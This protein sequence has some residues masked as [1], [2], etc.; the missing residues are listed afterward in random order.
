MSVTEAVLRIRERI[1]A[2]CRRSGRRVEE[3]ALMGVSKFRPAED[4]RAAYGAGIRLFGESRVQEAAGKFPELLRAH[5]DLD[6]H[7]IGSLQR[8]KAK[9]AVSLFSCVQS[10]DR[11]DLIDELALRAAGRPEPLDILFE[12]RTAEATKSGYL[13]L[14]ALCDATEAALARPSLR[15]RGLMTMA[16]YTRDQGPIRASFRALRSARDALSRRF[17]DADWSVLSMGMSNDF[18][19]AVEEGSSLL[20]IGTALFSEDQS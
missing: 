4:I 6:L 2:A 5:G 20:R 13:D 14:S 19:I 17:P 10:V 18:E 11:D 15:I 12:L 8:N 1:E 3:I 16:P 9:A 7:L